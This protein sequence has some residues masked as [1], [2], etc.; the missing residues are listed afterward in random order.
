MLVLS[1]RIGQRVCIGGNVAVQVLEARRG[2]IRLG[3]T[4]PA[5]VP[6]R[7]EELPP[8]DQAP[9]PRAACRVAG[10]REINE[11]A[12][13]RSVGRPAAEPDRVPTILV[14]EDDADARFAMAAVLAREGYTPLT[15]AT[16]HDALE[17]VRGPMPAI[18][19]AVLDVHLPD[20]SGTDLCRRLRRAQPE[21]P[22]IVSTGA[23]SPE[24]VADLVR[25]GACRYLRKP[26][27]ADEL[28]AT[29][30]AVLP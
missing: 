15:A 28:V 29:V 3:I 24:E 19:V 8:H 7:C 12:R 30:E 4:A 16:A 13:P 9:A 14:V 10:L 5:T 22:V 11:T 2:Q 23:A 27:T 6:I 20:V 17:T 25:Q 21:L 26:V 18:D 1:R